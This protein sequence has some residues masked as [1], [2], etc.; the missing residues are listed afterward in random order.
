MGTRRVEARDKTSARATE[1]RLGAMALPPT[2]TRYED[3]RKPRCNRYLLPFLPLVDALADTFG[4][5]CEVLLHD[6]TDPE[7]SV[8]KIANGHVTRRKVGAPATDFVLPFVHKSTRIASIA[9]YP[10]KSSEGAELRSTTLLIKT[11]RGRAVGALCINVDLTPLLSARDALDHLCATGGRHQTDVVGSP[12]RFEA[13]VEELIDGSI[14]Q[15]LQRIGKPVPYMCKEDKLD[16]LRDLRAKG[17][18][19]IKGATRRV[20]RELSVSIATL[21]KYLEKIK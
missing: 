8:V 14:R 5:H 11:P 19:L 3:S 1:V 7:H 17:L 18:F 15:S 2:G 9:A 21:Y 16:V 4:K 12:E 13:T 20:S 6:F 10:T